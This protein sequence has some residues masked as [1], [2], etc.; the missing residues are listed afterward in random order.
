M[1]IFSTLVFSVSFVTRSP[2]P[3]SSRP[4]FSLYAICCQCICWSPCCCSHSSPIQSNLGLPNCVLE[5][6]DSASMPHLSHLL[7]FTHFPF[8]LS[9][10]RSSLFV[11]AGLLPL[12]FDFLLSGM[13]PSREVTYISVNFTI[14]HT[15]IL[16]YFGGSSLRGAEPALIVTLILLVHCSIPN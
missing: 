10:S 14:Q 13:D 12:L 4:T 1:K 6:L 16:F 7:P 2:D 9:F 15:Y 11:H 3:F 8:R 5:P